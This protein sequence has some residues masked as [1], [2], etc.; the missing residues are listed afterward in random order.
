VNL[1]FLEAGAML[2]LG[3]SGV[4]LATA[5]LARWCRSAV[6]Q[7]TLWQVCFMASA[8]ILV[9]ETTGVFAWCGALLQRQPPTPTPG[10]G[11]TVAVD[12]T[13]SPERIEELL[14]EADDMATAADPERT[15]QGQE[16]L[17]PASTLQGLGTLG[18]LV[19]GIWIAGCSLVLTRIVLGRIFLVILRRRY[20]PTSNQLVHERVQALARQ[21]DY[22]RSV[23][24]LDVPELASAVAFGVV[25]PTLALPKD[26]VNEFNG[27]GQDVILAHELAHLAS[28]DPAWQLFADMVSAALWWQPLIWWAR[29]HLRHASEAAADEA[30]LLLA[31]GPE[32]LAE[33]LVSLGQRLL[34]RGRPGLVRM[35][36]SGFR[37]SLGRRVERLLR[38][39]DRTWRPANRRYIRLTLTLGTACLVATAFWCAVPARSAHPQ[40]GDSP[41]QSL[42]QSWR[43]SMAGVILCS[44]LATGSDAALAL[45]QDNSGKTSPPS[46]S[47]AGNPKDSS[48]PDGGTVL[49]GGLKIQPEGPRPQ[50]PAEVLTGLP[51]LGRLYQDDKSG[52]DSFV[53]GAGQKTIRI[54]FTIDDAHKRNLKKVWLHVE[55]DGG[56]PWDQPATDKD[57]FDVSLPSANNF[58]FSVF[59]EDKDGRRNEPSGPLLHVRVGDDESNVRRTK[60]FRLKH[61]EAAMLR[62]TL[63]GILGSPAASGGGQAPGGS[64]GMGMRMGPAG[65][66]PG[67]MG[68]MGSGMGAAMS[69]PTWRIAVDRATNS[70]VMRGTERDLKLVADLITVLDGDAGTSVPR[71][72]T[73]T[74]I[75]LKHRSVDDV[76]PVLQELDVG[77]RIVNEPR[78]NTLLV[79]GSEE[80]VKEVKELVNALDVAVSR[81]P[82]AG[83]TGT[84]G[85]GPAEKRP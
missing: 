32:A 52:R 82:P 84:P 65:G 68:A 47:P 40:E 57:H 60:V 37:S 43:R 30:S 41:M 59:T 62:E 26:F 7:R 11:A 73:F 71:I 67:K 46:T 50:R 5:A 4:V 17:V 6:G 8:L 85:A 19:P 55:S 49:L 12:S 27:A 21:L 56:P 63:Y 69:A 16:V 72:A 75:R 34:E 45:P 28:G 51:L 77:V 53:I 39:R 9:C 10:A 18:W 1:T 66:A 64:P 44:A 48:E 3:S 14:S 25:R 24:I 29:S 22:R 83:A 70:L 13:L 38:L 79:N 74:V 78:T 31:D 23:R 42:Q 2:A 76:L 35:A 20:L 33:C 54:P 80:A 61:A 81:P 15:A 58:W 36:G